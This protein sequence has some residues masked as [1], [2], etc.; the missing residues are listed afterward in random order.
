MRLQLGPNQHGVHRAGGQ[1]E[2]RRQRPHAPAALIFRLLTNPRLHLEPNLGTMFGRP[3]RAGRISQPLQS[4]D[5]K[6]V[7]PLADG[8]RGQLQRRGDLLVAGS[9][10][11][12]QH[13]AAALGQR[14][15]RRG[16][17]DEFIESAADLGTQLDGKRDAGPAPVYRKSFLV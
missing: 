7:T 4:P 17:M 3:S 13:D 14:L 8:D 11:R 1:S 12:R 16:G 10:G 9:V 5:G 6:R 2:F 15:R